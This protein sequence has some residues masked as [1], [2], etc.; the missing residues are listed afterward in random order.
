MSDNWTVGELAGRLAG[1][2]L[3]EM[4]RLLNEA[5]AQVDQRQPDPHQEVTRA[6]LLQLYALRGEEPVGWAL[7]NLLR[8]EL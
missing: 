5:G 4:A 1:G 3:Q 7:G 2:D 6:T 8:G